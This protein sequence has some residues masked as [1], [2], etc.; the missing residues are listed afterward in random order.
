MDNMPNTSGLTATELDEFRDLLLTKRYE[1][2]G[3][4]VS[5]ENDTL[6]RERDDFSYSSGDLVDMGSD[7]YEFENSLS[8]M[9][10]ERKILREI[11]EALE[12]MEEGQ[13]GIC[14][15]TGQPIGLA[16]LRAIPWA[17]YSVEFAGLLEKGLAYVD[18]NGYGYPEGED[19]DQDRPDADAA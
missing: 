10:S 15:G 7:N 14:M 8:L 18:E 2:L 12:R 1:I 9:D 19:Q 4:V 13:Y 17:K 16:R 11:D 6:K 3:N 5:I